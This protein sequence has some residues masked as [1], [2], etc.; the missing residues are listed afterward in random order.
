MEA[1][2]K[3]SSINWAIFE[4]AKVIPFVF[5]KTK[6]RIRVFGRRI[7]AEYDLQI[8]MGAT[9][10]DRA[11]KKLQELRKCRYIK[12]TN[13]SNIAKN[14]IATKNEIL[15]IA[16]A[17]ENIIRNNLAENRNIDENEVLD[18]VARSF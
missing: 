16:L 4:D 10:I 6:T 18:Q 3:L 11:L 13:K 2:Y 5:N 8:S 12:A 17:Y 15:D 1:K 7:N 9:P 14:C